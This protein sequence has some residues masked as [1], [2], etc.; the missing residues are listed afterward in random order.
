MAF[1]PVSVT[2]TTVVMQRDVEHEK[3]LLH[4]E[5]FEPAL[6]HCPECSERCIGCTRM[7]LVSRE[8][9]WGRARALRRFVIDPVGASPN[10][11]PLN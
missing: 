4:V 2:H 10:L 5:R 3:S 8:R 9:R 6:D 7:R 11:K 1:R